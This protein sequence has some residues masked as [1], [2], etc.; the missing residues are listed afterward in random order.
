[1][2]LADRAMELSALGVYVLVLLWIG[3]RSAREVKSSND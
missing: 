3:I 2:N 1:M